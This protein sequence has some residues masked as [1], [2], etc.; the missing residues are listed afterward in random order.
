MAGTITALA[1]AQK[2]KGEEWI[3]S[4]R[5][6]S[7][8]PEMDVKATP[9]MGQRTFIVLGGVFLALAPMAVYARLGTVVLLILALAAQPSLRH[10]GLA[11][12]G[13]SKTVLFR[14]GLVLAAWTA[15]TIFWTPVPEASDLARIVVVPLM[16]IL[17][18]GAVR[19]LPAP[20]HERLARLA[21][22]GGIL[23]LALLGIEVWSQGAV[24]SLVMSDPG[25]L[26][27]HQT[28][29]IVEAAARGAAILAPLA[30]VYAVLI[31]TWTKQLVLAA[32]FIV[33]GFAACYPTSM[34]AAWVAIIAGGIAFGVTLL[35]PRFALVVFFASAIL[36]AL[37]APLLSSTIIN[38][39]TIEAAGVTDIRSPRWIGTESRVEIWQKA[40]RLIAEQPVKG[41]GFDSS[42]RLGLP[43]HPHNAALQIWVELGG[44]GVGLVIAMLA[45]VAHALW[46][47]TNRPLHL[48]TTLAAM[49]STTV[50]A[51]ISFGIWQHWWLATWG[52]IA[53]LLTLTLRLGPTRV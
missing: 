3:A 40:A 8:N 51:L 39:D 12:Y 43:L 26:P 47:M 18:C 49:S 28:S 44:I 13:A 33:V 6:I 52:F 20:D 34:D 11:L 41:H 48:A 1:V 14:L 25:P 7:D 22:I 38:V 15:A 31:Y 53:A 36:Y 19:A 16:A 46:P 9:L 29:P 24:L 5:W 10:A 17:L 4:F 35:V 32:L 50:I 42:R 2:L 30:F 23:M 27:P 37:L 21:L 45:A